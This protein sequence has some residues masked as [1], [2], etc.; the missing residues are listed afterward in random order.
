[1]IGFELVGGVYVV[2]GWLEYGMIGGEE[3]MRAKNIQLP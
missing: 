2:D 3:K 1:L